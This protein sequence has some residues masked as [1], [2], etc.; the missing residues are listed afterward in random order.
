MQT[1]NPLFFYRI[2]WLY[3]MRSYT[4]VCRLVILKVITKISLLIW[5]LKCRCRCE[6]CCAPWGR[7][8]AAQTRCLLGIS[9]KY[10]GLQNY[11]QLVTNL[12]NHT[13]TNWMMSF[14]ITLLIFKLSNSVFT[15]FYHFFCCLNNAST[16]FFVFPY[17]KFFLNKIVRTSFW[18]L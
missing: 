4:Y 2:D 3:T 16:C 1:D 11:C 12:T 7:H 13:N 10:K 18:S 6:G 8:Q 9:V 17:H 15:S 14:S 5:S